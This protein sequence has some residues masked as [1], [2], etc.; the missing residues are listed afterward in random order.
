[1]ARDRESRFGWPERVIVTLLSIALLGSLTLMLVFRFVPGINWNAL[2]PSGGENVKFYEHQVE[3]FG[4]DLEE[5][6]ED[7]RL[8]KADIDAI[9]GNVTSTAWG[10]KFGDGYRIVAH[11]P[12]PAGYEPCHNYEMAPF[13]GASADT[14]EIPEVCIK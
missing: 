12:A 5:S 11:I 4:Y 9:F 14:Q 1:V 10:G 6:A 3:Q 8:E 7:A 13:G 2:N